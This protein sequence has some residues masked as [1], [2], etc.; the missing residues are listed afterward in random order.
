MELAL[1][2]Q[3]ARESGQPAGG[4]GPHLNDYTP[5]VASF[6]HDIVSAVTTVTRPVESVVRQIDGINSN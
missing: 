3:L 4:G 6:D 1:D 2:T 5:E